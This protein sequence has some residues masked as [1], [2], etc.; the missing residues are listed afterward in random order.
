M[1][2]EDYSKYSNEELMKMLENA[3]QQAQTYHVSQLVKKVLLNSLY[4]A[5]GNEHFLLYTNEMARSITLMGQC[6]INKAA[7]EKNR[8]ISKMLK[9]EVV[10]DRRTYSDTDSSTFDTVIYVNNE[11]QMIGDFY[12]TSEGEEYETV[13]GKYIKEL[14]KGK[15]KTLSIDEDDLTK[16]KEVDVLHAVKHKTPKRIW[17]VKVDG[18]EVIITEDHSI[19]ILRDGYLM[20][21]SV[22]DIREGDEILTIDL[23][24]E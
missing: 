16:I 4:G 14:P 17:K 15:Y 11:K 12:E 6:L 2:E 8:F 1:A 13:L 23:N 22:R 9:E 21:G 7:I 5:L 24:K 3:E 18:K 10:K 20:R 19:M